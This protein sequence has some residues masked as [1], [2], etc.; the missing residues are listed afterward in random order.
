MSGTGPDGPAVGR[1][2]APRPEQVDLTAARHP[3]REVPMPGANLGFHLTRLASRS[4][5]FVVHGH[6]PAGFARD[7][8]GGYLVDEEFVVLDGELLL[9]DVTYRRGDLTFVPAGAVRTRMSAPGGATVLAWFGG[10]AEF[11]PADRLPAPAL[12][13][14][15]T[16]HLG[17]DTPLPDLPG[18]LWRR[19]ASVSP[20]ATGDVLTA[21]LSGWR[22][23]GT[24]SAPGPQDF[25]RLEK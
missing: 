10:P 3:W 9:G 21:D 12:P 14:A 22:R 8:A 23:L 1:G 20:D 13:L 25:V 2:R 24:G 5:A 16:V 4:G 11:H 15:E 18:A 19:G 17:P 7:V 6:F